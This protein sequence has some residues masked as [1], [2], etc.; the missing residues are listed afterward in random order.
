MTIK[1]TVPR[2]SINMFLKNID[3][4]SIGFDLDGTLWDG[5]NAIAAS[6]NIFMSEDK[7][8]RKIP[9]ADELKGVMGLPLDKIMERFFPYLSVSKRA[10]LM[11]EAIEV[12]QSYIVRNGGILFDGVE[13]VLAKLSQKYKL[14]IVSNCQD[15]YIEA[16]LKHYG[17]EKYFCDHEC[18]GRTTRPKGQNIKIVMERNNFKRCIY[19]GDTQGD[20]EAAVE[21]GVLFAFAEYGF[22]ALE[23]PDECGINIRNFTDIAKLL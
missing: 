14:F 13:E 1:P 18:I 17:F 23:R 3:I 8:I 16:F 15:G 6:W 7:E 4:D 22:G 11:K 10:E 5:T 21:A 2:T 12:E 9:N 19:I 20:Y